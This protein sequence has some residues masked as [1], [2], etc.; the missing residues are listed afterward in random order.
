MECGP[1]SG[2]EMSLARDLRGGSGALCRSSVPTLPHVS[3]LFRE[4]G[5]KAFVFRERKVK[6]VGNGLWNVCAADAAW[7][8]GSVCP[9]LFGPDLMGCQWHNENVHNDAH[10]ATGAARGSKAGRS[11]SGQGCVAGRHRA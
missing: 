11:R 9:T 10:F 3:G 1:G 7:T 8:D 4:F 2:L 6:I 5:D